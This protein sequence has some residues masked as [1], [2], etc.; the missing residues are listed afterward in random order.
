MTLINAVIARLK[1]DYFRWQHSK[2]AAR[3]LNTRPVQRGELPFMLLSMVQKRDVVSYL[4][5][6][7][8]FTHFLNPNRIVIVCDPSIDADDR[9]ILKRHVPH[10]E[11]RQADEFTD[12][13]IPRGGTWERLYAITEYARDNYV[14]QLDADT[15]TTQPIPEVLA[16]VRSGKGFVLGEAVSTPVRSLAATRERAEPLVK[17]GAHIQTLS[18]A[19]MATVGLPADAQYVRGCSGFTGFPAS[20]QLRAAM[21]DFSE[22]MTGKLGA[23]WK[24]WGTEQVTSNYL[25]ANANGTASLPF[26][27]YGTPDLETGETAF[28]HFIGSMR[29]VNGK[30][31]ARTRQVI[32]QIN[33]PPVAERKSA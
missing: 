9:A 28:Y 18:E 11:L 15:V 14:I 5:A 29:F 4:V 1:R 8:S 32:D 22:R 24:R 10:V 30:Y 17:P 25:A 2:V 26:P 6:V 12:P 7:K 16:A 23:D 13:K 31:A 3:I 19:V 27:K 21:L 33:Q 20:A